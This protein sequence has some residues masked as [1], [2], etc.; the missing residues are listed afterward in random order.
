MLDV[1]NLTKKIDGKTIVENISFT[2]N[3]GEILG[4]VGPNGAGKTTTLRMLACCTLPASGNATLD[5]LDLVKDDMQIRRK[6]GY[7][8]EVPPLYEH[9]KVVTYLRTIARFKG[10]PASE[11]NRA[12]D[13]VIERCLINKM[14]VREI[15]KLSKGY[16]Q[17]VGLAQ[18]ILGNPRLLLLDEPTSGLDPGQISEMREIIRS[19]AKD[20]MVIFSTHILQEIQNLCHRIVLIKNGAL[21]FQGRLDQ[22]GLAD[23]GIT[24]LVLRLEGDRNVIES[25]LSL[26]GHGISYQLGE[27]TSGSTEIKANVQFP[28]NAATQTA[29]LKELLNQNINVLEVSPQAKD[30]EH[31][32]LEFMRSE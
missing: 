29:I 2:L 24:H 27:Q 26:E 4:F 10:I 6:I 23:D 19:A 9:M 15:G 12:V 3:E 18:A 11:Q 28:E 25:A 20:S 30:L 21:T 7:L 13:E 31:T 14:N 32:I 22:Y 16:R 5:G 1:R 17:R 8:P